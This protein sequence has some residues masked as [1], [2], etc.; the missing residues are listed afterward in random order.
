MDG[1]SVVRFPAE[2]TLLILY[3]LKLIWL[4]SLMGDNI[5]H[6]NILPMIMSAQHGLKIMDIVFFDFGTM[7]FLKT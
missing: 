2:N 1:N 4:S 3:A 7:K 6:L 5:I